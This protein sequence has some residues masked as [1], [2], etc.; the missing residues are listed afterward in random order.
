[1][2]EDVAENL[3]MYVRMDTMLEHGETRLC[4]QQEGDILDARDLARVALGH[5]L[6]VYMRARGVSLSPRE[7]RAVEQTWFLE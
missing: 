1:M 2:L 3:S 7:E 5:A 6:L 4:S